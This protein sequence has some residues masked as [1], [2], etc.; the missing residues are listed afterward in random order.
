MEL[1]NLEKTI[2]DTIAYFEGTIGKSQN[3]FDILF[4]GKKVMEG[5]TPDTK[6]IRHRCIK[7]FGTVTKQAIENAGYTICEDKTWIGKFGNGG[8]TTAAGRY[9]YLGWAWFDVTKRA[10]MEVNAPMSEENQNKAALFVIRKKRVTE[11][12]LKNAYYSFEGFKILMKQIEKIWESF[13]RSL[14]GGYHISPTMGWKFYVATFQ[15]Y[16]SGGTGVASNFN[17]ADSNTIYINSNG[18]TVAKFGTTTT[19]GANNTKF[20]LNVPSGNPT[21]II[22]IWPERESIVSR[23]NQWAQI[24]QSVK[25]VAYIIMDA[26]MNYNTNQN[27]IDELNAVVKKWRRD[28]N[29]DSLKKYVMGVGG[30]ANLAVP[31]YKVF[32]VTALIDPFPGFDETYFSGK[33]NKV[34]MVWGNETYIDYKGAVISKIQQKI[35]SD[36]GFSKSTEDSNSFLRG[37]YGLKYWFNNYASVITTGGQPTRPQITS[38]CSADPNANYLRQVLS[39]LGY[40]EKFYVPEYVYQ[41]NNKSYR[42]VPTLNPSTGCYAH[43]KDGKWYEGELSNGGDIN[44]EFSKV[45][46]DILTTIKTKYPTYKI[47]LTAGNDKFHY[48]R[49]YNSRHKAGNGLDMVIGG[50]SNNNGANCTTDE[51]WGRTSRNEKPW[52]V[53]KNQTKVQNVVEI[54][55][56]FSAS[57]SAGKIYDKLRYIDE[58]CNKSAP[59]VG[60][61]IHFSWGTGSEAKK[62]VEKA[63][64]EAG[65]AQLDIF[66]VTDL[67]T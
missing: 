49:S 8:I 51:S 27:S 6:L 10:G 41:S 28:I 50:A 40:R 12:T 57:G 55:R 58:Y 60:D 13:E 32:N 2:L 30:N 35:R 62:T 19:E 56:G 47:T 29:I 67:F 11:I 24:P 20:Y 1:T 44:E 3:G 63:K 22:Y 16:E 46:A 21:K 9:Q 36:M 42:D 39:N 53:S 15:K 18:Q 17:S 65:L 23:K 61:H 14:N 5:W 43:K 37:G 7:P 64:S 25:D 59:T 54:I 33:A 31:Y 52:N 34:Y 38:N 66:N 45:A 26:G 4:G 48:T